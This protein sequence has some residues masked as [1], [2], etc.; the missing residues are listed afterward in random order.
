V[1]STGEGGT[2]VTR[3]PDLAERLELL[4]S[5]GGVRRNG[6]FVFNEA[7]FNYRLSDI[8]AAV[9]VAQMRRLDE[10]VAR[11]R[12]L[13]SLYC[14]RLE[15]TPGVRM[16]SEPLGSR[17]VYQA[18]VVLLDRGIDR[19]AVVSGMRARAIE[20]TIGTYALHDQPFFSRVF[21]YAADRCPR[22]HEA[23]S[24]T[25]ALPLYPAMGENDVDVVT[26]ALVEVLAASS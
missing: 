22:S 17:H 13:A 6:R 7:G 5:H 19:D 11:R 14:E 25:L 1:V 18:F 16:P 15:G 20:T 24:R 21:G 23:F 3:R 10:I 4:R 8:H 9:G 12:A 2:V 26:Q